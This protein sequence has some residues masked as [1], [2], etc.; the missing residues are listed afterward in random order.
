MD[1][2]ATNSEDTIPGFYASSEDLPEENRS[3][4]IRLRREFGLVDGVAVLVGLIIGKLHI[5]M[6]EDLRCLHYN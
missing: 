4:K 1:L 3:G 5:I 2:P 6:N